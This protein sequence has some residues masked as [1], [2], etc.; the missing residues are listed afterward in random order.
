[1][2]TNPHDLEPIEPQTAQELYLDHKANSPTRTI[3]IR[4][5]MTYGRHSLSER[6]LMSDSNAV[7]RS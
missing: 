6:L 3:R 7:N 2:N 4:Q 5:P 1:M